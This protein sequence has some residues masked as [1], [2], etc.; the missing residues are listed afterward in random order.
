MPRRRSRGATALEELPTWVTTFEPGY[1]D[2]ATDGQ[3]VIAWIDACRT[4]AD[5]T[6]LIDTD[7]Q[8]WVWVAQNHRTI[9]IRRHAESNS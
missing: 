8:S 1:W 7:F 9:R 6:R 5:S 4:W 3:K 2:G